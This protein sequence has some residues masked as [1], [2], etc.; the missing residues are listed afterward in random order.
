[1]SSVYPDPTPTSFPPQYDDTFNLM[2]SHHEMYLE[3]SFIP[4]WNQPELVSHEI[5]YEN[6]GTQCMP[7]E[8]KDNGREQQSLMAVEN[9]PIHSENCISAPIVQPVQRLKGKQMIKMSTKKKPAVRKRAPRKAEADKSAN[10]R[11]MERFVC[12]MF[13]QTCQESSQ[14][15]APQLTFNL[16]KICCGRIN[17]FKI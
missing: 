9:Y 10:L 1:M 6:M 4:K 13:C 3:N 16:C 14:Y 17:K 12:I 5:G 8:R 2:S 11:K 15:N 7:M